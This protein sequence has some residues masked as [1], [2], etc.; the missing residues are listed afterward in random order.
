ML[1]ELSALFTAVLWSFT[2]L[3]FSSAA[4]K[5]GSFQLNI[6]RLILAA[7]FLLLTILILN[8]DVTLN[9]SQV[10]YLAVSGVVGLVFGDSFLFRAYQTIGPRLSILLLSSSPAI[11]AVLAYFFL[12]ERISLL[13]LIGMG[14][15]M[16]GIILVVLEKKE[17]PG[18]KYHIDKIGIFHG[19]M[20]AIGQAG[21]LVLAKFAFDQGEINGMVATFIRI[22]ASVLLIVPLGIL[23]R[24][25]KNPIKLYSANPRAFLL[26]TGGTIVGPYLGITFSL[27]AI[28]HTK[29]GIA[30]TLMSTM[31]IIMLPLM[32]FIYKEQLNWKAYAGAF[33]AVGGIAILFL[34]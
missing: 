32:K 29:V 5:I 17:I 4:R 11:T 26:T 6:N 8:F 9:S 13:G 2:S 21:G 25:Y 34:R 12:E 16:A 23:S 3:F 24:R 30:A 27:I 7:L 14:I 10:F 1:G 20:G 33:L 28:S 22:F 31:P 18:E 15:T 19:F